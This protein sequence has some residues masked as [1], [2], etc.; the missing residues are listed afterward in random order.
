MK[1]PLKK[2][3]LLLGYARHGKTTVSDILRDEYGFSLLDTSDFIVTDILI[4]NGRYKTM[5]EAYSNKERDR[6]IWYQDVIDYNTPDKAR[7]AKALFAA[8]SD[9]YVGMRAD[10]EYHATIDAVELHVIWVQDERKEPES[11]DSCTVEPSMATYIL[12]NSGTLEQ[13]RDN[14]SVMVQILQEQE[15][16]EG[17]EQGA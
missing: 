12:D 17:T 16:A 4:S 14:I 7:L 11:R 10:E 2:K 9:I 13:L 15:L 1:K 3:I 5:E 6:A 8:G